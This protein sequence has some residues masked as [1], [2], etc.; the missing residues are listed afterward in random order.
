MAL[1]NVLVA[2]CW[3]YTSAAYYVSHNKLSWFHAE[4]F[5]IEYCSSH[6]A[7]MH[8][9][10]QHTELINLL[11]SDNAW[12]GL[13][14]RIATYSWTDLSAFDYGSNTSG[15]GYPWSANE[16]SPSISSGNNYIQLACSL[17]NRTCPLMSIDDSDD[18]EEHMFICNACAWHTLTK[19]VVVNDRKGNSNGD[20][21]AN[22]Q[23]KDKFGT[24]LASV[25]SAADHAQTAFLC[26]IGADDRN[27]DECWIGLTDAGDEG[28]RALLPSQF[29]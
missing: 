9:T 1:S 20:G 28:V 4:T 10:S 18:A 13:T 15:G 16:P 25:H 17:D 12:I 6:L 24:S 5:C 8:N 11:G 23:C 22:A 19:Y 29:L 21:N 27:D 2:H 7:S 14:D 3:L 26:E